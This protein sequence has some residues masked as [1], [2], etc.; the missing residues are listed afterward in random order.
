[1]FQL[2]L[3]A[4]AAVV[5][6]GLLFARGGF[7]RARERDDAWTSPEPRIWPSLAVIVPARD[8]ADHIGSCLRSLAAQSYPG[9]MR[10]IVVDDESTDGTR[11]IA[12]EAGRGLHLEIVHGTPRPHG[13]TGK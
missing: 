4:A 1:M 6:C 7:W 2:S 3:A 8:E 12:R 13:W 10:V 11:D 9:P 5:W